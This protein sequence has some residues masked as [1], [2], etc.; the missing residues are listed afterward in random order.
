M[1][2]VY[3]GEDVNSARLKSSVTIDALRA[4]SPDA[5]YIRVTEENYEEFDFSELVSAQALFK[6]E[7]IVLLDGLLQDELTQS[8]VLNFVK[9]FAESSNLF[10]ILDSKI[11]SPTLKKLEKY[12]AKIQKFE[13]IK[14]S[15]KKE[16]FNSFSLTDAFA[17]HNKKKL[18]TLF[19]EAKSHGV[20]DEEIH[21]LFFW[22][23]KSMILATNA[24]SAESAGLKPFV[25]NKSRTFARNFSNSDLKKLSKDLTALPHESRRRGLPLGVSLEKLILS[26]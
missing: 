7:Y 21:G 5:L 24:S 10:F 16:V 14:S 12:A 6:N 19:W 26:F 20:S 17:E 9:D 3:Y 11:K 4:K 13:K 15:V 22:I 23:V 1:L 18:W 8:E 25:F 2:Y